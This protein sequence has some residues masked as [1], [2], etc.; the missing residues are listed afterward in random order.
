MVDGKPAIDLE[1]VGIAD[2]S[3]RMSPGAFAYEA[4]V[5]VRQMTLSE[6]A[7]LCSGKTFWELKSIK[8]LGLVGPNVSD[9]PHGVRRDLGSS[10]LGLDG[11][12]PATCFPTACALAAS[13]DPSL[14]R[15]VGDALGRECLA[16]EVGV[17][18]GPGVNIKRHPLC[19]RNFEY[20]SED[21]LVAGEFAANFILGVQSHGVGTSVKHYAANNQEANRMTIDTVVD[22]RTLREIYL[23]AFEAAVTRARPWTVMSAYNKLN[24]VQCSEHDWLNNQVLRDEWGFDGVMVTDWGGIADRVVGLRA[25]VDL[26]MPSSGGMNDARIVAAVRTGRLEEAVVDQAAMRVTSLCLAAAAT[27][28]RTA[29]CAGGLARPQMEPLFQKNHELARHCAAECAVLLKNERGLLPLI[30]GG[31]VALLGGFAR[32]PRHQG[33]GSSKVNSHQLDIPMDAIQAVVEAAGGE[34]WFGEGFHPAHGESDPPLI[35]QA[36]EMAKRS[37]VTIIMAGLPDEYESEGFDREHMRLPMQVDALIAAVARVQPQ[38]VVVLSNGAPVQMPWLPQVPTVLETYL[39]GQGGGAA[40]ADVLFGVV[41]P[42]GKLAETFPHSPADCASHEHFADHPRRLIY[43]EGLNV[44]Y[45]HFSTHGV[46]PLFPFGHGLSYTTFEYGAFQLSEPSIILTDAGAP[47]A[48][49]LTLDVRNT[50]GCDGAEVVQVYVAPPRASTGEARVFRPAIELRAF[51][52]VHIP[53]GQART[54]RLDLP[55]RAFAFYDV[56]AGG[57]RVEPGAYEVLACASCEDVRARATLHVASGGRASPHPD[58]AACNPPYLEASDSQLEQMG[59]RVRPVPAVRPYSIRTTVGEVRDD[60]GCCG[61]L[62]YGSIMFG[63]PKAENP[64]ENRLRVEMTR[65]LPLEI[66]F[67][68]LN[69]AFGC[70]MLPTPCLHSLVCCLNTCPH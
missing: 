14:A 60:G 15:R 4:E 48:V 45:R 66:L 30:P 57:W 29:M 26:E 10:H 63:L 16:L 17:L 70:V 28:A 64:V 27:R 34:L 32:V 9:G 43:R 1:R 24:G 51:Q 46:R 53:R 18:L 25:G 13:W 6:K 35:E 11:S 54:V 23:P 62:F 67:N 49:S 41:C 42:S 7:S 22:E 31:R 3:E 5:L 8:R 69:G 56:R 20:F 12:A 59:L 36:I 2:E 52:K 44:G 68:F 40:L 55:A 47:H 33:S 19:G 21:P 65:T 38:L 58:A 50:G 39:S 37:D 61:K